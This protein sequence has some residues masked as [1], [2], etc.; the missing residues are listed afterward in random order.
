MLGGSSGLNLMAFTL[1]S[2]AEYDAFDAFAYNSR[3]S[4]SSG[5]DWKGLEKYFRRTENTASQTDPY[6]GVPPNTN[7]QSSS[8]SSRNGPV[9]VSI[10]DQYS[11]I[12]FPVVHAYNNIGIN[13]NADA[14]SYLL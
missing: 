10:N 6:P 8:T 3:D 13:T 7:I 4:S 1:A 12:V 5:W 2:Q 11:D 14:V 9:E